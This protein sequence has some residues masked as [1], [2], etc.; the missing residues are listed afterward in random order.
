MLPVLS[1]FTKPELFVRWEP[2]QYEIYVEIF[3]DTQL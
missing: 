3:A 2:F 1:L